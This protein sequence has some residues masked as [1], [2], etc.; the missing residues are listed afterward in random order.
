MPKRIKEKVNK[1]LQDEKII[2][3]ENALIEMGYMKSKQK[4]KKNQVKGQVKK[5]QEVKQKK[6]TKVKKDDENGSES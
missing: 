6:E 5:K 3:H 1:D 2:D 4:K